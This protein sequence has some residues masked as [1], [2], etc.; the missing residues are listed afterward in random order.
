MDYSDALRVIKAGGRVAR[1]SWVEPGKYI[2]W[3]PAATVETPDGRCVE[4]VGHALFFRPFK[5]ENGQV[6]PWLPS[7][8]A[9]AGEDWYDLGTEG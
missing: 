7:F 9:Q 5:G 2:F 1:R 4:R 8:D 3:T 6:E